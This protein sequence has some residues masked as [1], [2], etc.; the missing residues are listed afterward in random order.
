MICESDG[1]FELYWVLHFAITWYLTMFVCGKLKIQRHR[2]NH[3]N[4]DGTG[5]NHRKAMSQT[6]RE[7]E[8]RMKDRWRKKITNIL[9]TS[10]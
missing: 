6:E 5:S 4:S 1:I 8:N 10:L 7:I 3:T 2:H 9:Q